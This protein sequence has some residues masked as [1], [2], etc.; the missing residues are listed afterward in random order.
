MNRLLN[1]LIQVFDKYFQ[2]QGANEIVILKEKELFLCVNGKWNEFKDEQLKKEILN[3]FLIFLAN[4]R[5]QQFNKKNR[6]LST[7]IPGTNYR[8]QALHKTALNDQ[9][10][11]INIRIPPKEIF[12]I[13]SF[14]LAANLPY[15]YDDILNFISDRK[16]ILISGG[17]GS[18]KTSLLNTLMK[19]IDI[20]ERL[21]IIQ[22]SPELRSKNKN[23]TSILVDKKDTGTFTYQDA[24]DA[25]TRLFPERLILGE[26]DTRNTLMSLRLN[27]TGHAGTISTVH[28]NSAEDALYAMNLNIRFERDISDKTITE[29]ISRA[30]D[31]IIQIERNKKTNEREIVEILDLKQY[32]KDL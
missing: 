31:Y 2:T 1:N 20:E 32:I 4:D 13:E 9:E 11:S 8:V 23:Q 10:F 16:N 3:D 25:A 14:K 24:I 30:I 19:K 22:D 18:G 21:V 28:A 7:S 6:S 17:T 15:S 5:E 29:Y 26:L 12:P 27:N